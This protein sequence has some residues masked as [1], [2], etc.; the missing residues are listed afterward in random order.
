MQD[1]AISGL[2]NNVA[3]ATRIALN[4]IY[5][6]KEDFNSFKSDYDDIVV[7][8]RLSE[9]A[10]DGRFAAKA[11][12]EYVDVA[13]TEQDEAT[14]LVAGRVTSLET[15]TT[16][17]RLSGPTMDNRYQLVPPTPI[18]VFIGSSNVAPGTWPEQLGT[19][20]GWSVKNFSLGGGGYTSDISNKYITQIN[21]AIADNTYNHADVKFVFLADAGNDIRALRSVSA[22]APA[23]IQAAKTAYPNARIIILPA[24]WG[25]AADNGTGVPNTDGRIARMINVLPVAE[26]LRE[27]ARSYG[28]EFIDYTWLW[29][30]DDPSLM[31]PN[32]VHYTPTGYTRIA[33][34]VESW[35]RGNSPRVDRGWRPITNRSTIASTS[36]TDWRVKREGNEIIVQGQYYPTAAL[37]LGT[38]IGDLPFGMRPFRPAYGTS[39]ANSTASQTVAYFPNGVIRAFSG[40]AQVIHYVDFRMPA[41]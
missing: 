19:R 29:N 32:E 27:F 3:S 13:I 4:A 22:E 31:M 18:A 2:I 1:E 7:T 15:L 12:L 39:V 37:G 23:V 17:G 6:T 5:M 35:L 14:G 26:E 41:F 20:M 16:T 38:D 11:D 30:W 40:A 34:Y 25:P 21:G 10:I 33:R 36:D 8:G 9:S 28:A 24:L